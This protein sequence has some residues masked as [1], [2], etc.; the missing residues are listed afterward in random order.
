M[1]MMAHED[2]M[3]FEN[4][5]TEIVE[6]T[7]PNSVLWRFIFYAVIAL[8]VISAYFWITDPLTFTVPF[9]TSLLSHPIFALFLCLFILLFATGITKR[10]A[11]TTIIISRVREVLNDFNITCDDKGKLILHPIHHNNFS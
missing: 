1:Q 6:N 10:M 11:A 3:A 8:T 9:R 5:L 2:L 4:R 7:K